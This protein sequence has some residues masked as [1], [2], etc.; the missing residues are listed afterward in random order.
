ML[1]DIANK[2]EFYEWTD[3]EINLALINIKPMITMALQDQ[4]NLILGKLVTS[5]VPLPATPTAALLATLTAVLLATL[6]ITF[7][8]PTTP[9]NP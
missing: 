5:L 7:I 9:P 8:T 2:K 3:E 6:I 1:A 4:L